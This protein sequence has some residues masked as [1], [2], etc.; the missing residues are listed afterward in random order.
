MTPS[1]SFASAISANIA[2]WQKRLD[3][4]SPDAIEAIDRD[5][6]NLYRAVDFGLNLP[7]TWIECAKLAILCF[8]FM[9]QKGYYRDWILV[10]DRVVARCCETDLTLKGRLLDQL[11]ILYRRNRQ[12]DEAIDS[13]LEEESIGIELDDLSR[14][15]FARMHLSAAFWRKRQ[16]ETAEKYGLAA[17]EGF[18]KLDDNQEKLASCYTNL[19]NIALGRGDLELAEERLKQA[20]ELYRQLNQ[21]VDH[22]NA[23]KNLAALYEAA[24]EYDQALLI[25]VEAVDALAQTESEID[26]AAIEI[27]IGTLYFRKGKMDLAEA[28]FRRADSAYMRKFGPV[29]YRALTANNL[30]NVYLKRQEWE[31]A[32]QYLVKSVRLFR[33]ASAQVYLANALS[34]EA[35]ALIGQGRQEEAIPIYDEAITIVAAHPD[36]AWAQRLLEEF[37]LERTRLL[38]EKMGKMPNT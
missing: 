29:Y 15:S 1:D 6:H 4:M 37:T 21:P 22:A 2:Y 14:Q 31:I 25:L 18:S 23:L 27:N 13:H 28:A 24:G 20:E 5:R 26:K 36:D 16:H 35:E 17:L 8:P 33:Q 9:V 19:G 3:E 32:E 10:L 11:G 38:G 7:D 34:G 12:L 30:G